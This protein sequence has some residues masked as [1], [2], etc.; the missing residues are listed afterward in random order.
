MIN[1]SKAVHLSDNK[2]REILQNAKTIVMVGLSPNID[3]AS[4]H[5]ASFLLEK[6]Y[7][8][9]PIYPKGGEILG[10]KAYTSLKEAFKDM[11]A[12]NMQCD[13]IDIFRKSEALPSIVNEICMLGKLDSKQ[14][15]TNQSILN[16]TDT[17][18]SQNSP[19]NHKEIEK[20]LG[21]ITST[22]N[23]TQP[24]KSTEAAEILRPF[25][26]NNLCVWVQLGLHNSE[27]AL[28]AKHHNLLYEEDSCIKLE[29]LRIFDKQC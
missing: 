24:N 14:N 29:Y 4:Y 22:P 11:C 15:L 17:L 18:P 8:I 21:F 20:K 19:V 2:K 1:N 16:I 3:K 27:A 6:G 10:K 7:N 9:I 23:P 25:N 13:I 5:V 26:I 28:I 12:N